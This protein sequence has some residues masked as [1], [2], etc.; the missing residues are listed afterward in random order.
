MV[1]PA[2]A[3][4]M[5]PVWKEKGTFTGVLHVEKNPGDWPK[6]GIVSLRNAR[7]YVG[8][9]GLVSPDG[10]ILSPIVE[11]LILGVVLGLGLFGKNTKATREEKSS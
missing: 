6:T 3:S 10:P 8:G 1:F 11:L 4:Q 9:T 2:D 7:R 5:P